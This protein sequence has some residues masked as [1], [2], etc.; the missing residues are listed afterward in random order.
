MRLSAV[1]H[2]QGSADVVVEIISPESQTRDR[3]EKFFEYE[4]G[5]VREY[6]LINP[7]RKQAEF[8][9]RDAKGIFQLTP[10]GKDGVFTS[11]ISRGFWLKPAWLFQHPPP[12]E[13]SIIKQWK[14]G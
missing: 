12:S 9:L 14:L 13:W 6:W 5:G 2:L 1:H 4:K 7:D 10:I 11:K 8:Y 3:G